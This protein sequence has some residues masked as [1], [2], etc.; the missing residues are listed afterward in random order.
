MPSAADSD[1]PQQER[2]PV[3][4]GLGLA[5]QNMAEACTRCGKCQRECSFLSA[6]GPPGH[7]AES[8]L[9][10]DLK[11]AGPNS[12]ASPDLWSSPYACSLCALCSSVCPLDLEPHELFLALRREAV[13][14]KQFKAEKYKRLLRYELIGRSRIFRYRHLPAHCDTVFFPGCALPGIRPDHTL[15]LYEILRRHNPATGIILDCCLKPSHDLG[16]QEFFSSGFDQLTQQLAASGIKTVITGCPNCH[17]TFT[18]YAI[19]LQSSTI[20]TKLE[21]LGFTGESLSGPAGQEEY[22]IHDPCTARFHQDIHRAVRHLSLKSGAVIKEMEHCREKTYCC[23][24]GGAVACTAPGFA[25]CWS[26]RRHDEARNRPLITYCAGC[27]ARLSGKG[28]VLHLTDVMLPDLPAAALSRL[29]ARPP[30]TY[31]NRLLLK[32]KLRRM[33]RQ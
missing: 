14:R 31:L 23:G 29:P 33:L 2:E 32:L 15:Q 20:F 8:Y 5:L 26:E 16:R 21:E 7:Q 22:A 1:F 25:A 17:Q 18:R 12:T 30:L 24:E 11:G 13:R 4:T 10:Q 28:K 27:T 9:Q 3:D 6:V 19:S